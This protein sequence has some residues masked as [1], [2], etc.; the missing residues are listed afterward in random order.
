MVK[1]SEIRFWN[2]LKNFW[3]DV[4]KLTVIFFV[5]GCLIV[6]VFNSLRNNP[7]SYIVLF[8]ICFG[9]NFFRVFFKR[10]V[11]KEFYGDY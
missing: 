9:F 3:N 11:K 4:F 5:I 2:I 1:E 10:E 6:F 8:M 7:L